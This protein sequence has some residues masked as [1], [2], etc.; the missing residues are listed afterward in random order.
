MEQLE[1]AAAH[2]SPRLLRYVQS[3][4]ASVLQA[5]RAQLAQPA[6]SSL[7]KLQLE[8]AMALLLLLLSKGGSGDEGTTA[9]CVGG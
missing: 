5:V 1:R 8:A 9:V 4:L 7:L 2:D 6:P 3:A